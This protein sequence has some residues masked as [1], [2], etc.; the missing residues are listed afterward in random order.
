[1]MAR[2]HARQRGTALI[3]AL[4]IVA[5]LAALAAALMIRAQLAVSRLDAGQTVAQAGLYLDSGVAQAVRELRATRARGP[6]L[7][8]QSWSQLRTGV[9]IDRGELAWRAFDLQARFNLNALSQTGDAGAGARLAWQQ[10]ASGQGLS[11]ETIAG[12]TGVLV[13]GSET[14]PLPLVHPSQ[15]VSQVSTPADRAQLRELIAR[16]SAL[17]ARTRININTA[18]S[19]LLASL[20]PGLS[21]TSLDAVLARRAEGG[22]R[23]DH[24][25]SEWA[26]SRLSEDQAALL[27]LAPL[28]TTSRWFEIEIETRLDTQVQRRTVVVDLG[29]RTGYVAL[30]LPRPGG[31]VQSRTN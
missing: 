24:V 1:M 8:G 3:Q 11:S 18:P 2:S 28:S 27:L 31:V 15:L 9:Q 19:A 20:A 29:A 30:S 26:A 14:L 13:A 12:L 5:A 6:M 21:Q 17:P 23:D 10:F 4:V 16:F 22:F 25:L 7:N